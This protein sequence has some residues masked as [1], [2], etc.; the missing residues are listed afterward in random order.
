[1]KTAQWKMDS[2]IGPLHLVASP[3]G[4]NGIFFRK[5]AA[6]MAVSLSGSAPEVRVL[7]RAARELDAYFAGKL[8]TFR[9]PLDASGTAFQKSVWNSLRRIPYGRTCSYR[10][11]A[12]RIRNPR[13]VRAVG[14]ANGKNPLCVI[15]PCH[16]VI[17][18]DGSLGGYSGG[19]RI[20]TQLL[21]HEGV[22]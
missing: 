16:R 20:K 2:K 22:L 10:D 14:S 4:L 21:A 1:M 5:Q 11:I 12:R 15:V 7:A 3:K 9:V 13:A 19:I 18:H 6:P 17:S 8:K